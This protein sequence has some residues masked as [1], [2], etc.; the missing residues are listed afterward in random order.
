MSTKVTKAPRPILVIDTNILCAEPQPYGISELGQ[1]PTGLFLIPA[2]VLSELDRLKQ[3]PE[4]RAKASA[5][6]NVLKGFAQRGALAGPVS[7]G[8]QA[9]LQ[10]GRADMERC[11]DGLDPGYADDRILATAVGL[12]DSSATVVVVTTDFAVYAR[13]ITLGLQ[14]EYLERLAAASTTSPAAHQRNMRALEN[15]WERVRQSDTPYKVLRRTHQLMAST[16]ARQLLPSVR[17]SGEPA[18]LAASVQKL[19]AFHTAWATSRDWRKVIQATL[20]ISPP[21]AMDASVRRIWE[22]EPGR[23]IMGPPQAGWGAGQY[24][25]ETADERSIRL[26]GGI[27]RARRVPDG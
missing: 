26:A 14:A 12:S 2:T 13:A 5:A 25:S 15:Q 22:A 24:R 8:G 3:R 10:I 9:T 7:C 4:M 11:P 27:A 23:D 20:G 16:L 21:G 6:L 1:Y 17:G 19:D 18:W